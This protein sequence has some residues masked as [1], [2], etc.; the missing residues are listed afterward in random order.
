MNTL[1]LSKELNVTHLLTAQI[2]HSVLH[3]P[4]NPEGLFEVDDREA[5]IIRSICDP[6]FIKHFTSHINSAKRS[7]FKKQKQNEQFNDWVSGVDLD[8]KSTREI[9][10]IAA[11]GPYTGL[12]Q[13]SRLMKANG[14]M[15][16]VTYLGDDKQGRRWF[17][18]EVSFI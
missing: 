6:V 2:A 16:K 14:Y 18:P 9:E 11:G 4:W 12:K 8:G 5:D 13:V 7:A 15:S 1:T 17:K 3:I 10:L